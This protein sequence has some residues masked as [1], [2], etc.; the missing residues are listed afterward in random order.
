MVYHGSEAN[1]ILIKNIELNKLWRLGQLG[2]LN[3]LEFEK[4]L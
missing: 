2:C 4:R 3:V 1:I